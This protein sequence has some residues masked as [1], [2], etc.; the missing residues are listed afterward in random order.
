[1]QVD[2]SIFKAYDIRGIVPDQLNP[3]VVEKIGRAYVKLLQA[4]NPDKKLKVVVGMDMRTSGPEL[5]KALISGLTKAGADVVDIGLSSTPTF[6]FA[7]GYYGYDGGLQISA[8][9]NPKEYNGL[10]MVRAKAVP[11]SGNSGINQIRDWVMEDNFTDATEIGQVEKLEGVVQKA[12]EEEVRAGKIDLK[13]IKPFKIVVDPANAMGIL[14]VEIM[15]QD[16]PV[17]LIKLNWELDGTFPNHEADPLKEENLKQLQKAVVTQGADLGIAVDGDAD[18]YF[19][20]DE[21]G[22]PMRQE[23]LRGIMAQEVLKDYPGA[24]ICYDI[25]PGKITVDMIEEAGG[26]PSVTKVGHSLIKEQM[27]KEGA[28]FGGESSGHYFFATEFGVFEMPVIL[29]LKFLTWL[30]KQNKPLSEAIKPYQ[31]YY[32]SGEI[33]SIVDDPQAKIKELAEKYADAK[34]SYLDGITITYPDFWFNVRPSNTEPKL[35]LNLEAV[36]PEIMKEKRDEVLKVIRS[37]E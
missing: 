3:N 20:V 32:H 8:S 37:W 18:R 23:I 29:V 35:R 33:N 28:P 31:K 7:V 26:K 4:E 24:I 6:Y 9:H 14:D 13:A 2:P 10:K 25:R 21:K 22:Q 17:E 19:F 12:Y 34:I 1:M 27:I 36:S 30:S 15:F 5:K 16:L 11:I